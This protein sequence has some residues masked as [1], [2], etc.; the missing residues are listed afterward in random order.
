M[1]S[2]TESIIVP[3]RVFGLAE[4]R[5]RAIVRACFHES[6]ALRAIALSCYMQGLEDGAEAVAARKGD[7]GCDE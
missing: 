4:R 6:N 2:E 7:T 5:T 3:R 1:K